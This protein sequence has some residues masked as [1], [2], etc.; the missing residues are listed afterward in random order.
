VTVHR[1]DIL[2]EFR[3]RRRIHRSERKGMTFIEILIVASL[4]SLISMALYN[5]LSNGIRVWERSRRMVI[6]EDVAIFFDKLSQDLRNTFYHSKIPF[7][8][9][10]FRFSFP[11]M[12]RTPANAGR[13][14][15][16]GEDIH[17]IGR[18]EYY[19]DT[20]EDKIYKRQANY[21]Q[22][23]NER[24]GQ[25]RLLLSSVEK[26]RFRY[27]YLTED[28]EVMSDEVLEF[29]PSSIELE[30]EFFDDKGKRTMRKLIDVPIGI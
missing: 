12:V 24:F 1:N 28:E 30:I 18:V 9:N 22:A 3:I 16:G 2:N 23:I 6:E 13:G 8:G 29:L 21:G 5:V 11:T 27:V 20:I 19:Y 25:P 4:I 14:H 7:D 10:E 26:F 15:S 17:Q